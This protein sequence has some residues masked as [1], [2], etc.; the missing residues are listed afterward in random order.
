MKEHVPVTEDTESEVQSQDARQ[1][2]LQLVV[3][4]RTVG[5]DSLLDA[6]LHG[7]L[8]TTTGTLNTSQ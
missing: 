4:Q 8:R 3:E 6:G 1:G 7:T 2:E 5:E